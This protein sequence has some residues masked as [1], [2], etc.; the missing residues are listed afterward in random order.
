MPHP[1]PTQ[2][3]THHYVSVADSADQTPPRRCVVPGYFHSTLKENTQTD[4]NQTELNFKTL[5]CIL[6]Q[7]EV[8][9]IG[10]TATKNLDQQGKEHGIVERKLQLNMAQMTRT[11][12]ANEGNHEK[13]T[14]NVR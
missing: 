10:T 8:M 5:Y 2:Y 3:H 1:L 11:I 9:T 12:L 6:V 13:N 7:L 4:Q 14:S